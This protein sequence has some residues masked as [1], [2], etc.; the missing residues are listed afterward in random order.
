MLEKK[1]TWQEKDGI[2]YL[3][4]DNLELNGIYSQGVTSRLGGVSSSP[5]ASLNLGYFT[6]DSDK[7]VAENRQRM[8][9]ALNLINTK[10]IAADQI[11]SNRVSIVSDKGVNGGWEDPRRAVRMSDAVITSL[12]NLT[13]IITSAD[14]VPILIYDQKKE[15]IA[16]VHAGWKGTGL[17]ITKKT[18]GQMI[19][20]FKTN[21]EDC[22]IALGPSIGICCYTVD[23]KV[24]DFFRSRFSYWRE[25][26]NL[27]KNTL[28]KLNLAEANR[29]QLM[30][31]GVPDKNI[32]NAGICTS[33]SSDLF[34]SYR[35]ENGNTGRQMSFITLAP[36]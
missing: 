26:F 34:F 17:E 4:F 28:G 6:G 21:P 30:E 20:N 29:R 32:A 23:I 35:K 22:Q 18:I 8:C 19:Q 33:C 12:R 1:V 14:C 9:R 3:K 25:I 11:H 10:M 31:A 13:L 15:V 36:K 7:N 2:K 24:I 5:Y 27:E 16:A